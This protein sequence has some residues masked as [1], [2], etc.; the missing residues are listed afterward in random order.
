MSMAKIVRV[1]ALNRDPYGNRIG[2]TRGGAMFQR[3]P[4]QARRLG[5]VDITVSGSGIRAAGACSFFKEAG[6]PTQNYE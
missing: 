2:Q 4:L 1:P 3:R 5:R 6:Y